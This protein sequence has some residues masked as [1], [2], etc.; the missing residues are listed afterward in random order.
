MKGARKEKKNIKE[1]AKD[2]PGIMQRQV[3][4]KQ[5][6]KNTVEVTNGAAHTQKRVSNHMVEQVADAAMPRFIEN[7][8]EEIQMVHKSKIHERKTWR[9]SSTL[10]SA[11]DGGNDRSRENHPTG[12]TSAVRT[13]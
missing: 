9:K 10:T 2:I 5:R 12:R 1:H 6:G 7:S 8:V 4:K 13:R 3:S 11:G